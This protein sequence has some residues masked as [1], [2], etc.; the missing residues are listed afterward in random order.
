[1]TY[2]E[3]WPA[4]L[5]AHKDRRSRALHY[6]GTLAAAAL[7]IVA[8]AEQEW[9]WL[10]AVPVAGYGAAWL[11]HAAF[12]HNRPATFDHPVWS[13]WSDLRML[14]LFLAGRLSGE[15]RRW[16]IER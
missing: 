15:L 8:V 7:I 9:R 3:F 10:I 2:A 16:A 12:E 1:M 14:R 6:I 4:Y 13:L 5:S 11:G